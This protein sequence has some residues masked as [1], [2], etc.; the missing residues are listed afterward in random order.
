MAKKFRLFH[1]CD[2][3]GSEKC[4]RKFLRAAEYYNC[5]AVIAAGDLTGKVII[6]I[7]ETKPGQYVIRIFGR[8]EKFKEDKLEKWKKTIR[9]SGYY[10]WMMTKE[11][12]EEVKDD[13]QKQD[14][15]FSKVMEAEMARWVKMAD[16][17]VP[18]GKLVIANPGNDDRFVVD[19]QI[20]ESERVIYPLHRVVELGGT[21][22]MVSCE[23]VNPTPWDSPRECSEE[24]L[25]KKIRKE[26]N[27]LDDFENAI[28]N[29]H[30]PPKG[31][32]LGTCPKL[33]TSVKPPKPVTRFLR[34]VYTDAGSVAV[35][36]VIDE[37]QPL[38]GLH[39]HI[40]ESKGKYK[41][42]R[43]MVFNA[44]SEY[45]SGILHGI[46]LTLEPGRL[47]QYMPVEA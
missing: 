30:A 15:I 26:I 24:E 33:D 4:W 35:R 20:L 47:V 38:L 23:W 11:E 41:L 28:F 6:P 9:D 22:Q 7:I 32:G 3:H 46:I 1:C 2:L 8:I 37:F 34:P 12:V 29:F 25:E 36:K 21:Y 18:K 27:R 13:P 19:E 43:T 10:P 31:T 14:E 5:D 44:G 40:H 16:E 39:G 42:G 17:I 45:T